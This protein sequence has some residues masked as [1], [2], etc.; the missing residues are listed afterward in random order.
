[1]DVEK[2]RN[3][4]DAELLHQQRELNDQLFRMKFQLKMGQTESLNKIRG[5]RKDVARIHT[6]IRE[7]E[8]GIAAPLKTETAGDATESAATPAA[9]KKHASARKSA[10]GKTSKAK[11]AKKKTTT[12]KKRKK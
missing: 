8:L 10:K 4:T 5:L 7:K 2:L 12:A 6:V 9:P 3:L 11:T 1:M